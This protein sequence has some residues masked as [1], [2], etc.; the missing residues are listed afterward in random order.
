MALLPE[1]PLSITDVSVKT[2][3]NPGTVRRQI[4]EMTRDGYAKRTATGFYI[5]GD[6]DYVGPDI[7]DRRDNGANDPPIPPAPPEP[8]YRSITA[9]FFGDPPIGR[10]ALD[11]AST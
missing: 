1:T 4:Y 5:R 7:A 10:S 8:K 6:F 11:K 3:I 9:L 2:G